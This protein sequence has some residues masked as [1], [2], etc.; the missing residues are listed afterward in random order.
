MMRRPSL[1]AVKPATLKPR[2]GFTLIELLVVISIIAVL[3]S[4]IA[5]A[6]QSSRR[7]ARNLQCLNHLKNLGLAITNSATSNGGKIPAFDSA[8]P[9]DTDASGGIDAA[10]IAAA[11]GYGWPVGLLQYLDRADMQRAFD[12]ALQGN[13]VYSPT[14][15][16]APATSGYGPTY[17]SISNN[18][19]LNTWLAVLTCPEDQNNHRQPLGL[20]YAANVGYVTEDGWAGE[21]PYTGAIVR[22]VD[23]NW[24]NTTDDTGTARRTGVFW[25]SF[26]PDG[27]NIAVTLDD[28]SQGDGLGQTILLAENI[29]SR[30][31][32]SRG[33]RDVGFALPVDMSSGAPSGSNSGAIGAGTSSLGLGTGFSL[34]ADPASLAAA[35]MTPNFNLSVAVGGA[36]RPAS[37]HVGT[38]NVVFTDGA[39]RGLN[40]SMNGNVLARLL[41]WDGQRNGQAIT[42]QSDY[43]N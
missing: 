36:P 40:A 25:R 31:F 33:L 1:S 6:V 11:P 18:P 42:N 32:I 30:S 26:T 23:I 27:A 34:S 13:V 16:T 43:L 12:A 39:A 35:N 7:A 4:L 19:Q 3:I 28:I 17:Q 5:P 14:H 15:V 8:V 24:A 29:Q 9:A 41:T 10:E 2:R 37:N 22:R 38:F 21:N 20:S